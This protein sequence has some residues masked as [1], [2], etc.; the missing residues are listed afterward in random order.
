MQLSN[1]SNW[2][3]NSKVSNFLGST[4]SISKVPQ[5]Y[6][7]GICFHCLSTFRNKNFFYHPRQ[8]SFIPKVN[9]YFLF[10]DP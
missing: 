2:A 6:L 10:P 5:A 8:L 9:V 1:S 7:V 3:S 4:T